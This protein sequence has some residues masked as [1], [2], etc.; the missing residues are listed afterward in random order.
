MFL[1]RHNRVI[2]PTRVHEYLS[3]NL[4]VSSGS[5]I[6]MDRRRISF[7]N[8][9]NNVNVKRN[10][11]RYLALVCLIKT[12]IFFIKI[13]PA[14]SRSRTCRCRARDSSARSTSVPWSRSTGGK[15]LA[16]NRRRRNPRHDDRLDRRRRT[17]PSDRNPCRPRT[18]P[19]SRRFECA[20]APA[21]ARVPGDRARSARVPN[22]RRRRAAEDNDETEITS[23]EQRRRESER[24]GGMLSRGERSDGILG[25]YLLSKG[26]R[27]YGRC[28]MGDGSRGALVSLLSLFFDGSQ[29]PRRDSH[30]ARVSRVL[31]RIV[32][33]REG[34]RACTRARLRDVPPRLRRA[35][36]RLFACVPRD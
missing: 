12:V 28:V 29:A 4:D 18:R 23:G 3:A 8:N 6:L 32:G 22:S 33:A 14:P 1:P 10:T 20:R 34:D 11:H 35:F 17:R 21:R 36:H 30:F 15:G 31:A 25:M 26:R 5:R 9:R 7:A 27:R 24:E 13:S 19:S 16:R 2:S